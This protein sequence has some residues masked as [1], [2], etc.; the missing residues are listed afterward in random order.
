MDLV[1]ALAKYARRHEY[2]VIIAEGDT[3]W[4]DIDWPDHIHIEKI[5]ISFVEYYW[6]RLGRLFE[7]LFKPE[8]GEIWSRYDL[9]YLDLY[10]KRQGLE[11]VHF[12]ANTI[13]PIGLTVPC[14]LTC[15]DVQQEYLPEFF[16]IDELKR[17]SFSY[18]ASFDFASKIV[19][20]SLYTRDSLVE[21]FEIDMEKL[22]LVPAGIDIHR[23]GEGS[24]L[25]SEVRERFSLPDKFLFYPSRFWKHKNHCGLFDALKLY[26]QKFGEGIDFVLTGRI[27]KE[28]LLWIREEQKGLRFSK[29][30]DLGFVDD[31]GLNGI[32]AT[33]TALVFPSLFEG[34]GIPLIEAMAAGC[35]IIAGNSTCIPEVLDGVGG[36]F[37]PNSP[38]ETCDSI[39]EITCDE[40]IRAE[41]VKAG[42]QRVE[43]FDWKVVIPRIEYVY[44]R[45]V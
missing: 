44:S 13:E 25:I 3:G 4:A 14:L 2:F 42:R 22:I 35:P 19:V 24:K 40:T 43:I 1:K 26:E 29:I 21:K 32:Y 45:V 20:P 5:K 41:F 36:L 9:W 37:D 34:F 38:K 11:F 8:V 17:R 10:A 18:R 6:W 27:E 39:R 15:W 28:A 23:F 31:D 33:A 16:S 12:P 30:V 7:E